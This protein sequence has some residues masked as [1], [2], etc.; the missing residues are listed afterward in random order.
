MEMYHVGG[1]IVTQPDFLAEASDIIGN[2]A[3]LQGDGEEATLDILAGGHALVGKVLGEEL[4]GAGV[5]QARLSA[6]PYE[7]LQLFFKKSLEP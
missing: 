6:E 1:S 4:Q 7:I 5:M 3:S 2:S